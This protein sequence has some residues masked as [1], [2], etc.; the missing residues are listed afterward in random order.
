MQNNCG[1]NP[2][3][4]VFLIK[5]D[6]SNLQNYSKKFLVGNLWHD[7]FQSPHEEPMVNKC[8]TFYAVLTFFPV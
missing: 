2:N 8:Q 7:A 4:V 3:Y 1:P 6:V 5:Q